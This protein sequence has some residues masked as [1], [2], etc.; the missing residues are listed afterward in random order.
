MAG[1]S[2]SRAARTQPADP[3]PTITKS[4]REATG[5]AMVRPPETDS[6]WPVTNPASS[7]QK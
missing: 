5:Q 3:A 7:E 2:L 1:F 4:G 6:V